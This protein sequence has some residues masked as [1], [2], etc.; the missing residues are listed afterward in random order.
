MRLSLSVKRKVL[1]SLNVGSAI[2]GISFFSVTYEITGV[3]AT[4]LQ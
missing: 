3:W 4:N 1:P 2:S